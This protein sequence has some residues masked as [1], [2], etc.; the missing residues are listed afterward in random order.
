MVSKY[1]KKWK[2]LLVVKELEYK[3]NVVLVLL[4]LIKN[5]KLM[6]REKY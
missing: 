5:E 2:I 3:C 4:L 6:V 1:M